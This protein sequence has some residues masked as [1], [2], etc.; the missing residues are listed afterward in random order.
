MDIRSIIAPEVSDFNA[1]EAFMKSLRSQMPSIERDILLLK[2]SPDDKEIIDRLF[3]YLCNIRGG[4]TFCRIDLVTAILYPIEA[5]ASRLRN[6]EIVFNDTLA[7][8]FLLAVDRLELAVDG[9]CSHQPLENLRL[10][11]LV[12]GLERVAGATPGEIEIRTVELIETVT[13]FRTMAG[14]FSNLDHEQEFS[15]IENSSPQ[16]NKDLRFFRTLANQFEARSPLFKGR[17]QRLQR[18]TAETNLLRDNIIDPTQLEAAVYMHDIGMMFLPESVWL[19]TSRMTP[20]EKTVLCSHP[21]YVEAILIRMKNWQGAATIVAQHH[22]MP[23]GRGYPEGLLA[24]QICDGAK[25]LAIV[26]AFEAIM[27][28]HAPSGKNL[29]VLRAIAEINACDNQFSPEWIEPF[30]RVIR[31]LVS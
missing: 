15:S 4:A 12:Q 16:I 19:K 26:D 5:L 20:E 30:N 28:K 25:I 18:L 14:V 3:R 21:G 17:M 9:L 29:S 23:D 27:L 10:L 1:L 7:K 24:D 13:G 31:R 11:P 22:E 8:V 6:G 2:T